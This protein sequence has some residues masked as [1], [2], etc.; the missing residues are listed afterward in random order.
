ML[1]WFHGCADAFTSVLFFFSSMTLTC[2][3]ARQVT[4][5][6]P[7]ARTVIARIRRRRTS[8][9]LSVARWFFE[10][11]RFLVQLYTCRARIIHFFTQ[12]IVYYP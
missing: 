1:L 4:R 5:F 6:K 2:Y 10:V 8:P 9:L 3:R 7:H 11:S 12:R